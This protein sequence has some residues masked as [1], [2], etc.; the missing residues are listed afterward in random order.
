MTRLCRNGRGGAGEEAEGDEK[1]ARHR[2]NL[3]GPACVCVT[4]AA[5]R[6][7]RFIQLYEYFPSFEI[8]TKAP[9]ALSSQRLQPLTPTVSSLP[10]TCPSHHHSFTGRAVSQRRPAR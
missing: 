7:C 10:L 1:D 3:S 2:P 8:P 9:R 5:F 6:G 4:G